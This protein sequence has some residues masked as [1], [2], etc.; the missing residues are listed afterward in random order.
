MILILVLV[1]VKLLGVS[2]EVGLCAVVE[3]LGLVLFKEVN[4]LGSWTCPLDRH[5]LMRVE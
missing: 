5:L 2:V 4:L 3:V 1:E